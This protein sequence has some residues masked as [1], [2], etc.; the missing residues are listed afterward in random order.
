MSSPEDTLSHAIK[1]GRS[2]QFDWLGETAPLDSIAAT[3]TAMAN[4]R[5]GTFVLGIIGPTGAIIGV[6]DAD[7]AIDR[8][9]QAALSIE[10]PLLI[11]LPRAVHLSDLND[12][13]VIAAQI[14]PG[15]PHVYAHSGRYLYRQGTENKVLKTRDLHRLI[16]ERG[17]VSFE[18]EVA[19]D[20]SPNDLDWDKI[21]A[22]SAGMGS[23][24]TPEDLLL[25]RG[26]LIQ[27]HDQLHPTN[28]GV[29]LFGKDPQ[30]YVRSAEIT[31]VR[32]AGE[33]MSDNFT[34]D[35]IVGALPDQ[36][37]RAETFLIDNLRKGVSLGRTMARAE[38][39]E[40]PLEAV[41]ELI[42]NAV[43]HRDYSIS[44]D[45]IRLFI[46][47]NRM[48]VTSPGNLPG[49]VTLDNIRE[50]RFSR[51]PVIVQVLSDMGFIERLGYGVDR[52][53]ALM[54][55]QHLRAP[56]FAE[57]DGGFQVKLF[58]D[59]VESADAPAET[60]AVDKSTRFNGAYKGTA[61]NPRQEAAL[62]HLHDGNPRIT[63]SDLQQLCP[64]V[65]P[66]TIRRDL[67]D[68]VTKDILRKMGAKRG[69][70]YVLNED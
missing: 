29:L 11:P 43:A 40:Y 17:E 67:V 25:K 52:V 28:A 4:S 44:G 22:Y 5:G 10:P 20:A 3:L 45:G 47:R 19:R 24:G 66:E 65:H 70:Y 58:N 30:R 46:F 2:E 48:E 26:C 41:R 14:P 27:H 31:A 61:I 7:N 12:R 62:I 32:F 37:R 16:I 69:S 35:D 9:V 6:R 50:E 33:I 60:P 57:T 38:N 18:T 55:S 36:I 39:F 68:L 13:P 64:D 49:P 21:R 56:E 54:R 42:V 23:S 15:M 63:N 59:I 51:N 34:R 1:Q 53:I 8:V